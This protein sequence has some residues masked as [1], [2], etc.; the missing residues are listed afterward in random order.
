[1]TLNFAECDI[2]FLATIVCFDY[3]AGRQADLQASQEDLGYIRPARWQS[4][5]QALYIVTHFQNLI[6]ER[7]CLYE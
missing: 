2:A 3:Q 4:G 6:L 7:L 5:F 1:M